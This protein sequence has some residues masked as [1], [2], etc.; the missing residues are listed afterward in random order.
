MAE[1]PTLSSLDDG[2]MTAAD[3]MRSILADAGGMDGDT[4]SISPGAETPSPEIG[5]RTA[6]ERARD[7]RGRFA[8]AEQE[9]ADREAPDTGKEKAAFGSEDG[10]EPIEA[11]GEDDVDPPH[12]WALDQQTEFRKLPPTLKA[13]VL[14][15]DKA[16]RQAYAERSRY[17]GFE[18]VLAPRRQSFAMEGIPDDVSALRK[19]F[20]LSDFADQNPVDFIQQLMQ[21]KGLQFDPGQAQGQADPNDAD[22]DDPAIKSMRDEIARLNGVVAQI[23][24][25]Q[26][27]QVQ[28]QR[29]QEISEASNALVS[30][31]DEKD[32]RGR[33]KNP[34]MTEPRIRR[35]MSA[36]LRAGLAPDHVAAYEM[37]CRAD[38]DVSAKIAASTEAERERARATEQRKKA[39]A[40][41]RSGSSISGSPAGSIVAPE[42][43]GKS[44]REDLRQVAAEMGFRFGA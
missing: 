25:G 33:L 40:A 10:K 39:E 7:D 3:E 36:M 22:Y 1:G 42:L 13:F 27:A 16:W 2:K 5:D 9:A 8:R 11:A 17:Q 43:S 18:S 15:S 37:S 32:E 34:Y 29:Q 6:A 31:R 28:A 20:A 41:Q 4:E 38:P 19:M 30:F 23:T 12:D 24:G 21:A 44:A 35:A 14:D 26:Q